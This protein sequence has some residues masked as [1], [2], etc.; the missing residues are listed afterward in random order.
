MTS[1][2]VE[3][4][5][6]TKQYGAL[7]P[8]R[9]EALQVLHGEQVAIIGFD[10]PAAEVF[11]SLL[12]GASLPDSGTMTVFGRSTADIADSEDWLST[13]DR[14][15]IVSERAVLLDSLSVVQNLAVPFSLDIEPP[16]ADIR[17]RA[18]V[19]AR[20]AALPEATWDRPAGELDAVNRLKIRLARAVA[21]APSMLLLEHPSAAIPREAVA[22]LGREVRALSERRGTTAITLSMDRE[23]AAAAAT[24]ILTLEPAT[25]RLRERR[26]GRI[27]FWS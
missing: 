3:I 27:N 12:T 19:L 9:I 15:G 23:F 11:I 10:Q 7:R 5:S 22:G 14:F 18:I 20:E 25:G 8:L 21:L 1:A 26:P 13:L 4:A 16:P 24:R 17:Q 6:L 2:S